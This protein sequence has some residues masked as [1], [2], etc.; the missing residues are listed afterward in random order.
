MGVARAG[1]PATRWERS[2]ESSKRRGRSPT[3]PRRSCSPSSRCETWSLRST[4]G[5]PVTAVERVGEALARAD[6]AGVP[7]VACEDAADRRSSGAH[8]RRPALDSCSPTPWR[9]AVTISRVRGLQL[10]M[11]S[12]PSTCSTTGGTD[13]LLRARKI[14]G[15]VGAASRRGDRRRAVRAYS[16][17]GD[18]ELVHHARR[19]PPSRR[20]LSATTGGLDRVRGSHFF[21]RR[22]GQEG[23]GRRGICASKSHLAL[24]IVTEGFLPLAVDGRHRVGSMSGVMPHSSRLIGAW[25][26]PRCPCPPGEHA[27]SVAVAARR[28][29]DPFAEIALGEVKGIRRGCEPPGPRLPPTCVCGARGDGT[30]RPPP[31]PWPNRVFQPGAQHAMASSRT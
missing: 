14:A 21:V 6:A 18:T 9:G 29:P 22:S 12:A 17:S 13:L 28:R 27:R 15:E 30:I 16:I 20:S 2:V 23:E 7:A 19:A 26:S 10:S 1:S 5:L 3:G 8:R 25:R 24:R 11:S 4:L 31:K